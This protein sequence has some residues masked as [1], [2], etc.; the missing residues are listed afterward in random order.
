MKRSLDQQKR[1]LAEKRNQ[2][3]EDKKAFDAEHQKYLEQLEQSA[4]MGTGQK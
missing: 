1:E 4:R 2:F 3:E